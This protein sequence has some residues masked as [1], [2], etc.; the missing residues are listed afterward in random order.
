EPWVRKLWPQMLIPWS[1]FTTRGL[2][3]PLVGRD[4]L[5]GVA[6]GAVMTIFNLIANQVTGGRPWMSG[7]GISGIRP[8]IGFLGD[9]L[10]AS[11]FDPSLYFFLLFLCRVVLRR[12]WLAT[13]AFAAILSV[14]IGGFSDPLRSLPIGL[15]F[16][17]LYALILLRFGFLAT[18]TTSICAHLLL[19]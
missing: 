18:I 7:M 15:S 13:A 11:I 5:A 16:A 2:R 3:D 6:F 14:S 19:A 9:T 4:L 10:T 1:R 17:G 12:R 8:F